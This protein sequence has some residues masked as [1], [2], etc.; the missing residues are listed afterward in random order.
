MK[1]INLTPYRER[2][3]ITMLKPII[4]FALFTLAFL[5]L[6]AFVAFAQGKY[7]FL[8]LFVFVP[9]LVYIVIKEAKQ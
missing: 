6:M 8:L 3:I 2:E 9:M 7:G 1:V 4:N 5:A